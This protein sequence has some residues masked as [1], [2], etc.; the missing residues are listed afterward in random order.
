M[1]RWGWLIVVLAVSLQGVAKPYSREPKDYF[2]VEVGAGYQALLTSGDELKPGE[3]A[4]ARLPIC[5]QWATFASRCGRTI[6]LHDQPPW[7]F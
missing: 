7:L 5:Y 4:A 3:G 6:R 1:K 2:L